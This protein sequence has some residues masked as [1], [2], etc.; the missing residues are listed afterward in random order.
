MKQS[1]VLVVTLMFG[2]AGW[3]GPVRADTSWQQSHPRREQV[4]HRLGNQ[5]D[6]IHDKVQNGQM[7]PQQA[8]HLHH[9]DQRIRQEEQHMARRDGGHISRHDQARINRQE[10]HVSE[11]ISRQ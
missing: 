6:R 2:L 10:N 9:E 8:R 11:Q 5:N 7:S 1:K 3:V 4:N